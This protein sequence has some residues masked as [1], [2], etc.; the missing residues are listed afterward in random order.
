MRLRGKMLLIFIM[1]F[2]L[3]YLGMEY[4]EFQKDR[5]AVI[6]QIESEAESLAAAMQATRRVY[7]HRFIAA[8]LPLN[9]NTLGLLPAHAL[10]EISQEF[11][12]FISTGLSFNNVSD[13]ARNPHNQ[14]DAVEL[15]AMEYFREN[16]Q[17]GSHMHRYTD[18]HGKAFY[19]Y[20]RPLRIE[21]YCLACHGSR[22]DAP[23]DI[24]AAYD[25]AYDYR[26]GD[27]RGIL[28]IKLPVTELEQRTFRTRLEGM[29]MRLLIFLAVLAI[30]FFLLQKL[31]V[32]R[33]E[34]LN[35]QMRAVRSGRHTRIH[36][37]GSDEFSEVGETING[38]AERLVSSREELEQERTFLH[39]IVDDLPDSTRIYS[40][41]CEVL[42]MNRGARSWLKKGG[43]LPSR[44]EQLMHDYREMHTRENGKPL[45]STQQD[46]LCFTD[47]HEQLLPDGSRSVHEIRTRPVFDARGQ[48][49]AVLEVA[50]D[51]T[52]I[53]ESDTNLRILSLA[54]EQSPV[55]VIITDSEGYIEYINPKFTNVTGYTF[56]EVQGKTP[57]ILKT[58]HTTQKEYEALWK[59]IK[60]GNTWYGE[61]L[62]RRKNGE[63]IW[64]RA[65]ISPILGSSGEIEHF[66]A[67]KEDITLHKDYE[68]RLFQKDN[69]DALTGL[70]NRALGADRMHQALIHA[71]HEG[72]RT[73]IVSLDIDH[74]KKINDSLG[75]NSGDSLLQ[76]V[77]KR[78]VEAVDDGDTV[79]RLGGDEF[80]VILTNIV[81]IYDLERS[82]ERLRERFSE[83]FQLAD[84]SIYITPSLGVSVAPDDGNDFA[85]LLRNA[86]AAQHRAKE[87]GRNTTQYFKLEMNARAVERLEMEQQLRN[88]LERGE[89]SLCFQPQLAGDNKKIMGAEALL[90]WN[91]VHFGNVSPERF[92]PL[93][94]ETG[95]I[96]RIS[97][98][99]LETACLTAM[100]WPDTMRVSV[101]ISPRQFRD[102][103]LMEQVRYSLEISGLPAERLVVEVTENLLLD[104]AG[105][106]R[107]ILD[108]LC[109]MG[110]RVALDDFGTGYS[111]LSYL[112][113]YPFGLLKIDR[114]FV[115]EV[116]SSE[117]DAALCDAII[118]MSHALGL[119]VVAEGV[120][121]VEQ[122][123]F[124]TARGV[125]LVQG[126]YYSRPLPT[127]EFLA[128]LQA[129]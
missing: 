89:F 125:D 50:R 129:R 5:T 23:P 19:H 77:A 95:L 73:G 56:E 108:E 3:P 88:A 83:P 72:K 58:G 25:A 52:K 29:T 76:E 118:R 69:Y 80:L 79:A 40:L 6:G 97:A 103:L 75:H 13:H 61:L 104:D 91:N 57:R 126:Y 121:T 68:Q 82:L 94:E 105:G 87:L 37:G 106:A 119:K 31:L 12:N 65:T 39:Q 117:E 124:L 16:P 32:S 24:R 67:V 70:P 36:I 115:N 102:G 100:Q 107:K 93:A 84:N 98:W 90:R 2:L 49:R 81:N 33:L 120:E 53:V 28:S 60:S 30:L 26:V 59:T 66:L 54:V 48:L 21:A 43:A 15:Q 128:W 10:S 1:V 111:S 8:G 86:D 22:Q 62:N 51:V 64:E 41:G 92:I 63:F 112:K 96:A 35:G 42:V 116:I 99:V 34:D 45:T 17:A 7:H 38:M 20:S 18:A 114:S 101:N 127:D 14:A 4:H 109:A 123:D 47:I 44:C 85:T 78:L 46:K 110:L 74:F 27:L 55:S 11:R 122:L 9:K 71:R 113:H